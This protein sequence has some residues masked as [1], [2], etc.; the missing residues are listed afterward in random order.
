MTLQAAPVAIKKLYRICQTALLKMSYESRMT[1][2]TV[3][4]TD[5]SQLPLLWRQP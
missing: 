4:I 3:Q 1:V 5:G 2:A